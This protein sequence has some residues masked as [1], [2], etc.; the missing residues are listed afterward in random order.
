[1]IRKVICPH[2]GLNSEF[3]SNLELH[4]WACAKDFIV[5]E[6]DFQNV[7]FIE[8]NDG[9]HCWQSQPTAYHTIYACL[10]YLKQCE[11]CIRNNGTF[12]MDGRIDFRMPADAVIGKRSGLR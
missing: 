4:C 2:C 11:K 12:C 9:Y 10:N 6:H 3:V 1:M 5:D 7:K 8:S